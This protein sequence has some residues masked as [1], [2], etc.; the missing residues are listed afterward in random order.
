M[1]RIDLT[2]SPSLRGPKIVVALLV[3]VASLVLAAVAA[4]FAAATVVVAAIVGGVLLSVAAVTGRFR[5][6]PAA[7]GPAPLSEDGVIEARQVGGHQWVAYGWMDRDISE[8]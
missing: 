4:L 8:R 1:I 2:S 6:T 7:Q 3:A 5:R